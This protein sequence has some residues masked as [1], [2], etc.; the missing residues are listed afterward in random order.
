MTVPPPPPQQPPTPYPA[1]PQAPGYPQPQVPGYPQPQGWGLQP[2]RDK[3]LGAGGIIAIVVASVLGVTALGGVAHY[4]SSYG[5]DSSTDE[6]PAPASAE[7]P[8]GSG[9]NE[10]SGRAEPSPQ[11]YRLTVPATLLGGRY[12]L[13]KDVSRTIDDGIAG[14]RNSWNE[15]NM[16]GV[17]GQYTADGGEQELVTGGLY[18]EIAD[19]RR[20]LDSMFQGMNANPGVTVTTPPKDIT[21]PGAREPV[22]CERYSVTRS[23]GTGFVAVCGWGDHSTAA[24]VSLP[25][26]DDRADLEALAKQTAEV[27]DEMRVPAGS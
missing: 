26:P 12:T 16:K 17:G 5:H 25:G 4:L 23:G 2:P 22:T 6:R 21:P 14:Q 19:P 8:R 7:A 13:A 20:T 1:P 27:R 10:P 3:R 18:G 11:R 9:G 15:R 24:T